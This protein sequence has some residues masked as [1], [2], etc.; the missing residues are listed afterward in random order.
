MVMDKFDYR[1]N[2][3][4]IEKQEICFPN[5][6][7]LSSIECNVVLAAKNNYIKNSCSTNSQ[8]L[9]SELKPLFSL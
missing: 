7:L 3:K 8:F 4:P 1:N 9:E 5:L 6:R 2:G